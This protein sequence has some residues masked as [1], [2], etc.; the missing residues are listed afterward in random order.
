[1]KKELYC[2]FDNAKFSKIRDLLDLKGIEYKY[3]VI[4]YSNPTELVMVGVRSSHGDMTKQYYIY[5][6]DKD[7]EKAQWLIE[8][9]KDII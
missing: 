8:K 5:V 4:D 6:S 9:S 1:M 7:L 3:K 2:G